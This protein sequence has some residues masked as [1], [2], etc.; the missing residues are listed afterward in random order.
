[1]CY[2]NGEVVTQNYQMCDVT[3][4]KIVEILD[5]RRPQVTFTCN[6][7]DDTCDF[8]CEYFPIES[9][10]LTNIKKFGLNTRN[11]S[12]A[13]SIRVPPMQTILTTRIAQTTNV[14]MSNANVF[15]IVCFVGRMDLLISQISWMNLSEAPRHSNVCR[16]MGE[17]MIVNSRSQKWTS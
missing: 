13:T 10:I 14:R 17:Q 16:R 3:N 15:Q 5:G 8:Q 9:E 11:H 4:V 7:E 1:M 6:A 12:I 2:Q